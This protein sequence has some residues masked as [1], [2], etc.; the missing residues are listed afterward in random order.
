MYLQY[1]ILHS[2]MNDST[3]V[4]IHD[5][6][7][8]TALQGQKCFMIHVTFQATLTNTDFSSLLY[9]QYILV[10][11]YTTLSNRSTTYQKVK[12]EK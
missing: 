8:G 7:Q 11:S 6:T 2:T 1:I 3:L 4:Q 10:V 9:S 5:I 12:I